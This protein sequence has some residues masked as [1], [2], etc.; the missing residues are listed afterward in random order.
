[1]TD[2]GRTRNTVVCFAFVEGEEAVNGFVWGAVKAEEP[3]SKAV[4]IKRNS[5]MVGS[6]RE[7]R[8]K[9][10]LGEDGDDP[11]LSYKKAI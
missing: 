4:S 3:D 6:G 2:S 11:Y 1:M 8:G 10:Q 5:I 7:G 9:I